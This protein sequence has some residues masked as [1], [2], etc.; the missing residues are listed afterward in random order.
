MPVPANLTWKNGRLPVT[1][2]FTAAF[3]GKTDER[4]KSYVFRILRRLES[5]FS[6]QEVLLKDPGDMVFFEKPSTLVDKAGTRILK[7]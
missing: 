5:R 1:K 6:P 2:N 3:S 7:F 4:L